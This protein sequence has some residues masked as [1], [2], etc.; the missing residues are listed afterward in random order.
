MANKAIFLDRDWTLIY[1]WWYLHK[2][3]D[4]KILDWVK[5]W[6]IELK[7]KWYRL[8]IISNQSG[9]WRWYFTV[10]DC[11]E[12]NKELERQLWIKFDA[13]YV[14]P[15]APND[16]CACRKP[17]ISNV[18]KAV[19]DFDL[20]ITKCF[21]VWDKESD[22]QTWINAWCKTVLIKNDKHECD[23]K[24]NFLVESISEFSKLIK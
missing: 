19:Q 3:E 10:D 16:R 9:I 17:S 13:I 21:F 2:V 23:I 14:C 20:D 15:H 12:F 11:N 1:D 22:I 24:P 5:E 6:L 8:I 18:E 7:S 4:I